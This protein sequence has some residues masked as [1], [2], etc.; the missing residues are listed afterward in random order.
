MTVRQAALNREDLRGTGIGHAAAQ[1][2]LQTS[3]F[4]RPKH[5][6]LARVRLRTSAILAIRLA[7]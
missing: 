1:Q 5:D 3:I 2:N 7:Q 6:R 4:S